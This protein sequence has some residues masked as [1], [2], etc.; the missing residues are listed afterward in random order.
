MVMTCERRA[1]IGGDRRAGDIDWAG[2]AASRIVV[3]HK[4]LVGIIR[5]SR[6]V[7]LRLSNVRRGLG[8]GHQIDV[9][10]AERL[11]DKHAFDVL[12]ELAES[13]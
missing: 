6:T 10:R 12:N 3:G 2:V 9:G 4:N 7:R 13:R 1:A 8:A 11:R 5:I